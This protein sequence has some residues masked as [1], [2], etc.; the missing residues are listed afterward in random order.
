MQMLFD[1]VILEVGK[2]NELLPLKCGFCSKTF[3]LERKYIKSYVKRDL[4][5]KRG[6]FCSLSCAALA[7]SPKIEKSCAQCGEYLL[8]RPCQIRQSKSGNSFCSQSCAATYNNRNK[9]TGTRRSKLE[10][11]M[12]EQL[13][14]KYPNLGIC[15]NYKT[16]INSEL[17]IYLP[18][19][20]TAFEINGIF[21]YKPIYG[22]KKFLSIQHNDRE[23]IRICNELGINLIII[24]ISS[25]KRFKE[26]D[27]YQYL[28]L[29]ITNIDGY[30]L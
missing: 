27:S 22:E 6:N 8:L 12:E 13:T 29:I 18:E 11:W 7:S 4:S 15:F 10:V 16:T 1:P 28:D 25:Q 5:N 24:D 23:K 19:L 9:K 26:S 21:H 3:F 17:D 14:Q 30:Q 20:K 2:S